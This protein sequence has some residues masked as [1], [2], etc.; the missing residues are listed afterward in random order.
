MA[1]LQ[2]V[3]DLRVRARHF[4]GLKLAFRGDTKEGTL[5]EENVV[6]KC[7]AGDERLEL[8]LFFGTGAIIERPVARSGK[9]EIVPLLTLTLTCD[10]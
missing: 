9:V 10:H 5:S 4:L 6:R 8:R 2:R 7:V 1:K 3:E